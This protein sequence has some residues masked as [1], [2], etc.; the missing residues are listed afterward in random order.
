MLTL[1]VLYVADQTGKRTVVPGFDEED[2]EEVEEDE[3]G[4]EDDD[5]MDIDDDLQ[6]QGEL[7]SETLD[8]AHKSYLPCDLSNPRSRLRLILSVF[9]ENLIDDYLYKPD[10]LE[11]RFVHLLSRPDANY[12]ECRMVRFRQ[13][14]E[15]SR[16]A[17]SD[18]QERYMVRYLGE[19]QDCR[20]E[21][22]AF[23]WAPYATRR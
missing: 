13:L 12:Q 6:S 7:S 8:I 17:E 14:P 10:F 3:E 5:A 11:L 20:E 19:M 2:V 16:A 22:E 18:G 4:E 9:A 23:F 21:D 1:P 15:P